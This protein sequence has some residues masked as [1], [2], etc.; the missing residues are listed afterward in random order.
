MAFLDSPCSR[1]AQSVATMRTVRH[2]KARSSGNSMHGIY[3]E[4][5]DAQKKV[6]FVIFSPQNRPLLFRVK[7]AIQVN[8]ILQ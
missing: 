2:A 5:F 1:T 3:G 4:S 6:K 7:E 8:A